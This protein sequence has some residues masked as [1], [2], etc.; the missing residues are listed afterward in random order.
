MTGA[1]RLASLGSPIG[2][3]PLGAPASWPTRGPLTTPALLSHLTPTLPG[4]EGGCFPL[5]TARGDSTTSSDDHQMLF[6]GTVVYV[7]PI[8]QCEENIDVEQCSHYP[9][10]SSRSLSISWLETAFPREGSGSKP[11]KLSGLAAGGTR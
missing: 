7:I 4:E 9:G 1:L 3:S 11:K 2:E 8:Q 5:A 10:S 6:P